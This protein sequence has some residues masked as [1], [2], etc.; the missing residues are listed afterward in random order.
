MGVMSKYTKADVKEYIRNIRLLLTESV[1]EMTD[2]KA[3][4]II[5]AYVFSQERSSSCSFRGSSPFIG[6]QPGRMSG[7]SSIYLVARK[8]IPH[9]VQQMSTRL[10]TFPAFVLFFC[11]KRDIICKN[12]PPR[13]Q[14]PAGRHT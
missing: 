4:G 3:L 11:K 1:E 7:C 10:W 13:R 9:A 14:K 8:N 12:N 5:E 6:R 2:E